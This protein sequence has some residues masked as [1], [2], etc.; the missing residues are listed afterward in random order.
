MDHNEMPKKLE[1]ILE[2]NKKATPDTDFEGWIMF[3]G[4]LMHIQRTIP[5]LER[6]TTE[7]VDDLIEEFKRVGNKEYL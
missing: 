3:Q 1:A 6:I 4:A 2:A 7:D 5:L